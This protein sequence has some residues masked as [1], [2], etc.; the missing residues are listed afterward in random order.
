MNK[1]SKT[2]NQEAKGS[3]TSAIF[4]IKYSLPQT[5]SDFTRIHAQVRRRNLQNKNLIISRQF[6]AQMRDMWQGIEY[7]AG[8]EMAY[9]KSQNEEKQML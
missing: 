2:I 3:N 7:E 8:N 5:L 4:A 9:V 1:Y 6:S